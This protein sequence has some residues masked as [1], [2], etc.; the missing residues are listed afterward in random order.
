MNIPSNIICGKGENDYQ[1]EDANWVGEVAGMEVRK[2]LAQYGGTR[3]AENRVEYQN[4]KFN[5]SLYIDSILGI[6][7]ALNLYRNRED[8]KEALLFPLGRDPGGNF[9]CFSLK[10]RKS[11]LFFD[12]ENN[13]VT[14]VSVSW[15]KLMEDLREHDYIA[16]MG[17]DIEKAREESHVWV[18]P[19]FKP[20]F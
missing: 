14:F 15:S 19:N 9:V 17:I 8:I 5:N 6:K 7:E 12:H 3:L 16:D 18:D 4:P 20:E 13:E 2:L 1:S 10:D 11:I